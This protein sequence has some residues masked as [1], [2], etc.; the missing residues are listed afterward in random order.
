MEG[1]RWWGRN[2][3]KPLFQLRT[4]YLELLQ[5]KR[6]EGTKRSVFGS[7]PEEDFSYIKEKQPRLNWQ[8]KKKAAFIVANGWAVKSW[9]PSK[10]NNKNP[11]E[12]CCKANFLGI[13]KFSAIAGNLN[14]CSFLENNFGPP[15]PS[16]KLSSLTSIAHFPRFEKSPRKDLIRQM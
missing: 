9:S 5:L 12:I 10:K 8:H 15:A 11:S 13:L 14:T 3:K 6:D 7:L 4:C 16:T 2:W 1:K